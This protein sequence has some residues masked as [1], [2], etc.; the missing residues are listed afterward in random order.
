MKPAPRLTIQPMTDHDRAE[1]ILTEWAC[2]FAQFGAFI[3]AVG[4]AAI[5]LLAYAH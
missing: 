4:G 1:A 5:A 3:L 2:D